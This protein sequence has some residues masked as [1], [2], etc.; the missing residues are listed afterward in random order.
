MHQCCIIN[1]IIEIY[2]TYFHIL[3]NFNNAKRLNVL[4]FCYKHMLHR[5]SIEQS[6]KTVSVTTC[7]RT[8]CLNKAAYKAFNPIIQSATGNKIIQLSLLHN[9]AAVQEYFFMMGKHARSLTVNAH[10]QAL[11][12]SL[13]V[14]LKTTMSWSALLIS[15]CHVQNMKC[16]AADAKKAKYTGAIYSV[17]CDLLIFSLEG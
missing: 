12:S 3:L 9:P 14:G 5:E 1:V 16:R 6:V 2:Q 7:T 15:H 10:I 4:C 8:Q 11:S 17:S 13:N